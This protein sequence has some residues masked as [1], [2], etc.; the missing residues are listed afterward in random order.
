MPRSGVKAQDIISDY[1]NMTI[2]YAA[3]VLG[4][5]GLIGAV[6]L[7]VV[8]RKFYVFEDPRVGEIE[9]MLPGANC[10]ACGR[11]GCHDFA[12]ACVAA[13][14]LDGLNCPGAGA[15]GMSRIAAYLGCNA[16]RQQPEVA[17]VMC[18]GT[19]QTKTR[20]DDVYTGVRTCTIM[21]MT[22]GEYA[23]NNS[24]LGCGDCVVACQFGAIAIPDG[25]DT[26]VVD[27]SKCTGCGACATA[28]PRSIIKLRPIGPRQRRVWVA[29]SNCLKG[30][31][32]RKQCTVGCIGCGL[33]ARTCPFDAITV[34]NNLAYIDPAKCRTCG[35]C[36]PVCPTSAIK[37]ANMPIPAA[38]PQ[39]A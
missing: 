13:G 25:A 19:S 28:C 7:Y 29:C 26:P 4:C 12:V 36:I 22:A 21:N 3:I 2:L 9:T 20:L 35:K 37:S 10:G 30:A 39:E 27:T 11:S 34:T 23:C 8:S 24:C 1:Y 14:K 6:M 38:K 33:C 17:V 16:C 31:V 5:I 32:T 18:A 15:E